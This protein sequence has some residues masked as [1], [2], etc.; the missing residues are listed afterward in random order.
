MDN[1]PNL[2]ELAAER[3]RKLLIRAYQ[4]WVDEEKPVG[5]A[6]DH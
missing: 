5:R 3:E 4:I 1:K 2:E 6:L